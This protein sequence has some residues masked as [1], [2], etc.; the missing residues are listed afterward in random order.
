MPTK[1][2][3]VS[4]YNFKSADRLFFDTNIWI[5]L[6]GQNKP[7]ELKSKIYSWTLNRILKAE[8]RIYIDV[9]VVSEFINTYARRQ[10][11]LTKRK[12]KNF[13][14]F[15]Q[16]EQFKPVAS[17]IAD[18]TKRI[19]RHCKRIGSGFDTL[20]INA[21]IDEYAKGESDFNDQ[22]I[23]AICKRERL[24]L[25]TDDGDFSGQGI[26]VLTANRKMLRRR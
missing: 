2:I 14:K 26:Q 21:L 5:F 19:L 11:K 22:I 12:Y 6:F 23:A 13:K 16:S 25:I 3:E 17:E 24:T 15:R 8:S 7:G 9:L 10:F 1:P 20:A 4:N 18:V